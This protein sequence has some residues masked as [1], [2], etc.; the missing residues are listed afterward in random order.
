MHLFAEISMGSIKGTQ[1]RGVN[2][3]RLA[4]FSKELASVGAVTT[5]SN[6][7]D[8]SIDRSTTHVFV[9]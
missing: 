2:Q 4:L 6:A 3:L 9:I 7:S 1:R 5:A 8:R